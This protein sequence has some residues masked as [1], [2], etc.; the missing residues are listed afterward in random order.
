MNATHT[1]G[2]W[3]VAERLGLPVIMD[4]D[5]FHV[6][7]VI[8]RRGVGR[9]FSPETTGNARLIAAAPELLEALVELL[10]Q[11]QP[12]VVGLSERDES[13]PD[14]ECVLGGSELSALKRA[15]DAISKAKGLS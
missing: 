1:P 8:E 5:G 12:L 15:S 4:G 10:A 2:P 13:L 3:Q 7:D 6:A 11:V 9:G 14:G